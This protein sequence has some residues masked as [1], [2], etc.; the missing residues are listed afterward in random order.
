MMCRWNFAS[1]VAVVATGCTVGPDYVPPDPV[2][3]AAW[4]QALGEG[5]TKGDFAAATWWQHLG[6]PQLDE[7]IARAVRGNPSL[8][9]AL[10]RIEQS[11]FV[12]RQ[13]AGQNLPDING[14]AGYS[15]SRDS[16]NASPFP[17]NVESYSLGLDMVWELDLFGRIRRSVESAD[18]RLEANVEDYRDVLTAL[19]AEVGLTYVQLRTTQRRVVLLQENIALQRSSRD[20]AKARFETQVAPELDLF[21]AESNLANTEAQLPG[22]ELDVARTMHRL[23]V[24]LGE[25]A[26][27]LREQLGP[28]TPIPNVSKSIAVGIPADLLRRRPDIRQAERQLAAQTALIGAAEAQ[29]YPSLSLAGALGFSSFKFDRL[30]RSSSRRHSITPG[31]N[32]NVFDGGRTRAA[33]DEERSLAEQARLAYDNTVL[34]AIEEAENSIVSIRRERE[35]RAALQ[36]VVTATK[37][38]V[39]LSRELYKQGLRNFQNVLDA[40]RTLSGAQDALAASEGAVV[41][42]LIDLFRALGGGWQVEDPAAEAA[43]DNERNP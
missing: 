18:A 21:Q 6:D 11:R 10:S 17:F 16:K 32:F 36:R 7:L 3:P 33:V 29:L 24:L 14:P 2:M 1:F 12:R 31:L 19:Q 5:L 23:A 26:G 41:A 27:A 13:V 20:L 34:L 8:A 9:S 25:H 38:S 40:E 37:R 28:P 30:L 22:L 15:R 35:R 42:A 39:E 4:S 43:N